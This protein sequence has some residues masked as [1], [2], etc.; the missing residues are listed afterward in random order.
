MSVVVSYYLANPAPIDEYPEASDQKA[1]AIRQKLE[2]AEMTGRVNREELLARAR[3]QRATNPLQV[4][5][6]PANAR[7]QDG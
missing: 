3:N 6:K 7:N 5:Q 1:G 2:A 4:R